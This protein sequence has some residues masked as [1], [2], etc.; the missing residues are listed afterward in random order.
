M[1]SNITFGE[2]GMVIN[3]NFLLKQISKAPFWDINIEYL[4]YKKNMVFII[5]RVFVY[6]NENDEKLLN[7]I[8]TLNQIKKSVLKSKEL[9]ETVIGYLSVILN[10]K[11]EKFNVMPKCRY[12]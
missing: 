11:K 8:Y 7:K 5:E 4:D 9:T 1:L 12:I 10:I 6:G 2:Y 3:G